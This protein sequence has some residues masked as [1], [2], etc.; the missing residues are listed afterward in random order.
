MDEIISIF[1]NIFQ[2]AEA[3]GILPN[4]SSET[5]IIKYQSQTKTLQERKSTKQYFSWAQMQNVVTKC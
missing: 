3:E 2:K 1:Y 4:C 5:S